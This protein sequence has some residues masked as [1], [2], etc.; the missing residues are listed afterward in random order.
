MEKIDK[1]DLQKLNEVFRNSRV[2]CDP[3]EYAARQQKLLIAIAEFLTSPLD[4]EDK[5][6]D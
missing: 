4:H 5:G 3:I 1:T 2:V 6:E